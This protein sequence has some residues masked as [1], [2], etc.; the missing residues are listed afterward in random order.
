MVRVDGDTL[1]YLPQP[2]LVLG[3]GSLP[4]PY[5]FIA[6]IL[7]LL[8]GSISLDSPTQML[9]LQTPETSSTTEDTCLL[10]M[11]N[12][13]VHFQEDLADYSRLGLVTSHLLSFL[14]P[15][16]PVSLSKLEAFCISQVRGN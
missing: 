14:L 8:W 5:S 11:S 10:S 15:S 9:C 16:P 4:A 7:A 1:N 6:F 3:I 13:V 12:T 2:V